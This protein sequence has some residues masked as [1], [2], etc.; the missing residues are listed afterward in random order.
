M[1]MLN[2]FRRQLERAREAAVTDQRAKA[3]VVE[4]IGRKLM[5][6]ERTKSATR[7]R[8]LET[9]L[10]RLRQQEAKAE[11]SITGRQKQIADLEQKVSREE[12][13]EQRR[14]QRQTEQALAAASSAVGGLQARVE[15]L[16]ERLLEDVRA[17]VVADPVARKH[18]VFLSHAA[19]DSELAGEL[20]AEL[21]ARGLD[22]WFD[23]AELRLGRS[24]TRQIDRGIAAARV[25]VILVTRALLDGRYWTELEMGA[26]IS[27]RR[28][29]IPVL[30]GVTFSD[31]TTYSPLLAD[32]VGLTTETHGVGEIAEQIAAA[33]K[34]AEA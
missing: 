15:E 2:T 24:L 19:P 7:Q 9:E 23:G 31:L 11:Q 5:E 33:L 3:T 30:D 6:L 1:S 26:L 17:A 27:G 16:E 22:V 14:A 21:A 25:G 12:G 4:K 32:L 34:E 18:D 8:S 20:H 29:V 13:K 28:R 10:G